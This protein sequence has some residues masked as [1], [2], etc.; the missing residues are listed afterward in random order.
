[1]TKRSTRRVAV[2]VGVAGSV[3]AV[4]LAAFACVPQEGGL[5]VKNVDAQDANFQDTVTDTP[6]TDD[7]F[8]VGDGKDNTLHFESWCGDH[9]GHPTQAVYAQTNDELEVTVRKAVQGEVIDNSTTCPDVDNQLDEGENDIW[10]EI[11]HGGGDEDVYEWDEPAGGYFGEDGFWNFQ[12]GPGVGCYKDPEADP[13]HQGTILVDANGDGSTT[14]DFDAQGNDNE[15]WTGDMSTQDP[16]P[17]DGAA[18]LCVG[19][20][21][22]ADNPRSIFAPVVVASV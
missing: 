17:G 21:V 11:G 6:G 4:G 8:I 22:N 20:D 19:D 9:G 15:P 12:D 10:L 13:V 14:F 16:D 5:K 18:V 1:M 3:F 7:G 2:T